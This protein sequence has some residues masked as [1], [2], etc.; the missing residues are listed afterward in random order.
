[1]KLYSKNQRVLDLSQAQVMGILN[2]TPDSF[3]DSGKFFSLDKA[4]YHAEEMLKQGA[5]IIDVGGESTRPMAEEVTLQ[6]ELDRV[7][8]VVEAIRQRF[9]CWISVDTSKAEVMKA[10]ADAGMDLINDIRALTEEN[11]LQTAAELDLPVCLMHMQGQPKTMQA[12]P[13]YQN[14]VEEVLAWLLQRAAICEQAGVRKE[15]IILDIGFGF[16]K[17]LQHN[18]QLLNHLE[19]FVATGY[20]LLIGLSRKSMIGNLLQKDVNH[21]LV[22]SVAG[23]LISVMK[24]AHIVRVHDVEATVDALK[25][26]QAT[27]AAI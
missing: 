23:A 27:K 13:E 5:S 2:V 26:W 15:N 14:V 8:P 17:T 25:V 16:G 3:S 22:G 9:D 12:N 19:Q 6:Q 7:I 4:L 18:Y 11:A 24:G 21:R 1:M 10:A 20:P